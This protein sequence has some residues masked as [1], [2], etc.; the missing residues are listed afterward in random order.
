MKR[1]EEKNATSVPPFRL[2]LSPPS[3]PL[4]F[5]HKLWKYHFIVSALSSSVRL[6]NRGV[7]SLFLVLS[8]FSSFS[9]LFFRLSFLLPH[10]YEREFECWSS[11]LLVWLVCDLLPHPRD[12]CVCVPPSLPIP[13]PFWGSPNISRTAP[14]IQPRMTATSHH[15]F[16]PISFSLP[17][18]SLSFSLP[19]FLS[20]PCISH[21]HETFLN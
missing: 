9:R 20:L 19:V 21:T 2:V 14:C 4:L 6:S 12:V 17:L 7:V 13:P 15:V 16:P 5:P 3:C 11:L 18:S 1:K 8:S 10:I